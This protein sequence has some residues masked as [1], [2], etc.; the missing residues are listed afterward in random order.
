MLFTAF[1]E[2]EQRLESVKT[3][4]LT[5][6][7]FIGLFISSCLNNDR[8]RALFADDAQNNWDGP[9]S[10]RSEP[11]LTFS[12]R[13]YCGENGEPY[14]GSFTIYYP[15]DQAMWTGKLSRGR[16]HG[17][18]IGY[19]DD[20]SKWQERTYE[21]G[22]LLGTFNEVYPSG[23]LKLRGTFVGP[24]S[25]GGDKIKDMRFGTYDVN[26]YHI[27]DRKKGRVQMIRSSG[28]TPYEN[29]M[30]EL[31]EQVGYMLFSQKFW[32]PNEVI[33]SDSRGKYTPFQ[34]WD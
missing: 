29:E 7:L 25:Y 11:P 10:L 4:R 23:E 9:F 12:S 34:G 14:N 13:M 21:L 6:V 32:N 31:S 1:L 16:L 27:G 22:V 15:N 2:P 18:V 5:L 17:A 8:Q 20:G 26:G 3:V 30:I 28:R 24:S 33:T 19:Y